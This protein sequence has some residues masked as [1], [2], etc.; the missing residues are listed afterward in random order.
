VGNDGT[1]RPIVRAEVL[2]L[3]GRPIPEG[4][5]VD[6]GTD[7]MVL[8]AAVLERLHLLMRR[9]QP[10]LTLSGIGGESAFVLV[11][12]ALVFVREVVV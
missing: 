3:D 1:T 11:R 8:S 5:L 4:F 7:R 10:G 2:R 6:S 9:G 12:M